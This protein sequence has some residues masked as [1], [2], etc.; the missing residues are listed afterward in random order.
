MKYTGFELQIDGGDGECILK[1][2][3]S[4]RLWCNADH[5]IERFLFLD[6]Y[7]MVLTSRGEPIELIYDGV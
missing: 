6:H 1:F 7:Q 2:F 4:Y 5:E 3:P